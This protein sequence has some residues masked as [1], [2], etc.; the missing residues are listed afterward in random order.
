[1]SLTRLSNKMG[2][3]AA[4]K[5]EYHQDPRPLPIEEL[6][7]VYDIEPLT[8][9]NWLLYATKN[10]SN[11]NC[12]STAEFMEDMRRFKY[13]RKLFTKYDR[14]GELKERLILNH[15]IVLNNVLGPQPT[16]RLLFLKIQNHSALKPFVIARSILPK[17][18]YG[19][20]GID[21]E[22]DMISLDGIVAVALR[23][24]GIR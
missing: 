6:V 11:P 15:I 14:G 1:M 2:T 8:D 19:V 9:K 21:Y 12:A 4:W 7:S 23:A 13:L 5:P 17:K 20:R 18:I 16:T 22:T 24:A 10:Y 3:A